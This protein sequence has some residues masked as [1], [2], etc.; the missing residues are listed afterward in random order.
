M[1]LSQ[2]DCRII[3]IFIDWGNPFI[4][5]YFQQPVDGYEC[6]WGNV[7]LALIYD[8]EAISEPPRTKEALATWTKRQ[9]YQV[10]NPGGYLTLLL[11]HAGVITSPSDFILLVNDPYSVGMLFAKILSV[12]I[13]RTPLHWV[14]SLYQFR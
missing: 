3:N 5:V 1:V 8:S 6:P 10:F 12:S 14:K 9:V 11:Y 2:N 13:C 4:A 7:Q